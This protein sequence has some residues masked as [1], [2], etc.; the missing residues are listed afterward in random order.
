V[1]LLK[2]E[3]APEMLGS[4]LRESQY[5][6]DLMAFVTSVVVV[7]DVL[8]NNETLCCV[9]KKNVSHLICGHSCE[10]A[11]VSWVSVKYEDHIK[12]TRGN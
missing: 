2:K 9:I 4:T 3:L 11:C 1:V 10:I 7:G 6:K 8:I 5:S 12:V